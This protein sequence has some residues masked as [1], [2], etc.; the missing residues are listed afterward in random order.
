MKLLLLGY[1][2]PGRGDDGLGP[3][4]V[5]ALAERMPQLTALVAMQ[6]QVEHVLDL[7]ACDL[8]LLVDAG[9]GTPSPFTLERLCLRSPKAKR[10]LASAFSHAVSPLA[11][12]AIYQE[13]LMA[14]PPPAFLLTI[15]GKQFDFKEGISPAANKHLQAALA[16]A[17]TLFNK[18]D[19][20][21]WEAACTSWL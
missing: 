11:L 5:E 2:N 1:G 6:L 9:M 3:A 8:A 15:A 7:A 4:L 17:E 21:R 12:L 16:F 20:A 18:P 19:L 10:S 13:T 14:P